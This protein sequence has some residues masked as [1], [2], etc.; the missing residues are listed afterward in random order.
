M[1]PRLKLQ[2]SRRRSGERQRKTAQAKRWSGCKARHPRRPPL[3]PLLLLL[4]LLRGEQ[5]LHE[6]RDEL[7][8]G[9]AGSAAAAALTTSSATAHGQ[10]GR[11][12]RRRVRSRAH[13][14]RPS[15]AEPACGAVRAPL[16]PLASASMRRSRRRGE[17][18]CPGARG[19]SRGWVGTWSPNWWRSSTLSGHCS[20]NTE[21]LTGI[22]T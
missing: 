19:V 17:T 18:A 13:A 3:L 14:A 4:P 21:Q 10:R 2:T 11:A 16:R 7:A 5:H 1:R 22:P 20:R 8:R 9:G 12:P 6:A 15:H